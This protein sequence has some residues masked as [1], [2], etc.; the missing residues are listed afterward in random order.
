M[1]PFV[2]LHKIRSS[3]ICLLKKLGCGAVGLLGKRQRG[4]VLFMVRRIQASH[5][6]R[7]RLIGLSCVLFSGATLIVRG[8]SC[9]TTKRMRSRVSSLRI[10][11]VAPTGIPY[12][13]VKH[14]YICMC[15]TL[16]MFKRRPAMSY[17]QRAPITR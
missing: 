13:H 17:I 9:A 5:A 6:L 8:L 12:V 3:F 14:M 11:V 10:S 2:F 15:G 16:Q 1:V 4:C 7:F